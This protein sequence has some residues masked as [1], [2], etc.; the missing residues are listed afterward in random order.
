MSCCTFTR[1]DAAAAAGDMLLSFRDGEP[2]PTY[3]AVA[4]GFVDLGATGGR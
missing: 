2:T 4:V 1:A 3:L